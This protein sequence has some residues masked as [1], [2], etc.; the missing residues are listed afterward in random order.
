MIRNV[1]KRK[2][3]TRN[4]NYNK[5]RGATHKKKEKKWYSIG[6]ICS[7]ISTQNYLKK[8]GKCKQRQANNKK[9]LR[10]TLTQ[11]YSFPRKRM[12]KKREKCHVRITLALNYEI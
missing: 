11:D 7:K 2:E 5:N 8:R 3:M 6:Q 10:S 4:E 9:D 1:S 12:I